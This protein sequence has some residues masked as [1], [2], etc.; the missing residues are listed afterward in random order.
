[1]FLKVV[2][3]LNGEENLSLPDSRCFLSNV[4]HHQKWFCA[5]SAT[6]VTGGIWLNLLPA[7]SKTGGLGWF[8]HLPVHLRAKAGSTWV[9]ACAIY[10]WWQKWNQCVNKWHAEHFGRDSMLL[11]HSAGLE[12]VSESWVWVQR[13]ALSCNDRSFVS[14]P[15]GK[16]LI[17]TGKTLVSSSGGIFLQEFSAVMSCVLKTWGYSPIL[18]SC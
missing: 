8:P 13:W 12:I 7:A 11:E 14:Q 18:G 2:A 6:R 10:R 5:F 15:E 9:V 4:Q 17:V 3:L 1:M 16:G